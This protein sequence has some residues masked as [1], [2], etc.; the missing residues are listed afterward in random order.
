MLDHQRWRAVRLQP[1]SSRYRPRRRRCRIWYGLA[2]TA[3]GPEQPTSSCRLAVPAVR[4]GRASQ[5]R[6]ATLRSRRRARCTA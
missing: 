2:A 5:L 1:P 3:L 6:S 4:L